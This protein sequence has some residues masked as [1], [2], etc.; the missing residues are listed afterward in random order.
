[1]A[2]HDDLRVH[3]F[4]RPLDIAV[5]GSGISGLGAAWLLSKRHRVTLYEKDQRLGG[6]ANTVIA[7]ARDRHGR[8]RETPV[9]TG[10][11]VYNEATYPNLIALFDALGVESETSNM[12][13]AVSLDRGRV[14]YSGGTWTG[15]F[16]QPSNLFRAGH[17][18]MLRD[19]LRFFRDGRAIACAGTHGPTL[20]EFLAERRYCQGF[21]DNHLLPMAAAI[22]SC[23]PA[24]MME[25]PARSFCAFFLNHGLLQ[26]FDRPKWR[27]VKGGSREYIAKLLADIGPGLRRAPAAKSVRVETSGVAVR[28]EAGG[29]RQ[30]DRAILAC[31]ADEALALIDTPTQA[32]REILGDFTFQ[33][34]LAILHQD[35]ALMPKRKLAWASWN[36]LA[37][38]TGQRHVSVTYWMNKLQNLDRDVPLFV[39]LNPIRA[40]R[41]E[42]VLAGFE[43]MHPAFDTATLKAQTRLPE[44]QNVRGLLFAG[45]WTGYGF[46]EDGLRSG[47]EAAEM[48]GVRRPWATNE[49]AETPKLQ[50]AAE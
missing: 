2:P 27:T 41:P 1:M 26:I 39:S 25:F 40:P 50:A 48:L 24:Q 21:V 8:L 6:H 10:F 28:D 31:H 9:D 13:F 18:R 47:L 4:G 36:Y 37:E 46:H 32:E 45:A 43:Y 29:L 49:T 22:W 17:W 11:I 38:S 35:E 15:L 30:H 34:N 7:K 3:D 33:P 23:P 44:I 19:A 12:S 14:E 42:T 16:A 20:R 5:I